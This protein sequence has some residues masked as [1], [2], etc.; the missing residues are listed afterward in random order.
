MFGVKRTIRLSA[1]SIVRFLDNGEGDLV[2]AVILGDEG[3]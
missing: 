1:N 3:A 2:T